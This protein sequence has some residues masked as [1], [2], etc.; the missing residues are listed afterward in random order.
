MRWIKSIYLKL[1]FQVNFYIT[2]DEK[3]QFHPKKTS[4]RVNLGSVALK[5]FSIHFDAVLKSDHNTS[6][7][8][9][10]NIS[11]DREERVSYAI[12]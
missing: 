10:A 1:H 3:F 11:V 9:L 12:P 2:S 5:M 6:A 4:K 7:N 8:S